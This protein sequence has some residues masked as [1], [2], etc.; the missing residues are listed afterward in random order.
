M[1][2]NGCIIVICSTVDEI[3]CGPAARFSAP[4]TGRLR[5]ANAVTSVGSEKQL[6][7]FGSLERRLTLGI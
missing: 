3:I 5:L 1:E 6:C 2:C 4:P 7:R